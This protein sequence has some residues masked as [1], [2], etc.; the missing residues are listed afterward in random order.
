MIVCFIVDRIDKIIDGKSEK[1]VREQTAK[2][3]RTEPI[4]V[5]SQLKIS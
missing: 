2:D 3:I 5:Q 1:I 4:A